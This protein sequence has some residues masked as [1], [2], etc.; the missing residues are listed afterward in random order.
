VLP[1]NTLRAGERFEGGSESRSDEEPGE[2]SRH[3]EPDTLPLTRSDRVRVL[4]TLSRKGRGQR[5]QTPTVTQ[6]DC[7][8][9]G[10]H[11]RE[12]PTVKRFSVLLVL[13]CALGFM[14]RAQ[15]E[16]VSTRLTR[17][18]TSD[19]LYSF[20]I[21]VERLK[22]NEMGE[23]LQFHVT[24]KAKAGNTRPLPNR[25]GTLSVY[26]GKEFIA[27][28]DVQSAERRGELSYSF[29]VAAK[30]AEKSSFTFAETLDAP[31]ERQGFYYWFYLADFVE[32]K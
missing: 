22:D 9:A 2:G 4:T 25:T 31:H 11:L 17:E 24:V 16:T 14:T 27:S 28:C 30:H 32:P 10:A 23:S 21:K 19:H 29:R 20:T 26:A 6:H 13:G 3:E 1:H 8:S 5:P 15:A 12:A 7:E 18:K